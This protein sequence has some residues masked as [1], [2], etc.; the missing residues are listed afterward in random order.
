[1]AQLNADP[2]QTYQLC[3][4]VLTQAFD[5][6]PQLP[7]M[8]TARTN[9]DGS[10]YFDN[11]AA[12]RQYHVIGIKHDEDGRP[13]VIGAKTTRLRPGQKLTLELSENDPWTG[14]VMLR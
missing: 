9:P 8:A 10:F 3:E 14:P 11:V 5:L 4:R 12:G 7:A 1:M 2:V 13:I 6:I